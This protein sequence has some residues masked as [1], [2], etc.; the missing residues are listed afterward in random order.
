MIP[1]RWFGLTEQ[2]SAD[3]EIEAHVKDALK[4][5]FK[6]EFLNRIDEIIVF[7]ILDKE[8]LQKIVDIQLGYLG[9]RLAARHLQVEFTDEARSQIM[10]E[11]YDPV[12]G[13]RQV[14]LCWRKARQSGR[15]P[16]GPHGQPYLGYG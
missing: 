12:Y 14:Y 11:G 5:V 3:W 4:Q 16:S 13:A 9:E 6:P 8:H 2:D 7:H 15:I 10:D 1:M